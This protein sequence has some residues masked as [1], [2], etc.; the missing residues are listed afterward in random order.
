M[1][2]S[3]SNAGAANANA[4]LLE[5]AELVF[6]Q[7]VRQRLGVNPSY[8]NTLSVRREIGFWIDRA[9]KD[10]PRVVI[11]L[12]PAN[13]RR[14]F[15]FTLRSSMTV[16]YH[17]LG[18][19]TQAAI[20]AELELFVPVAVDVC[21]TAI[22]A[23]LRNIHRSYNVHPTRYPTPPSYANE[24]ELPLPFALAIQELGVFE[25]RS[26]TNRS[27]YIPTYPEDTLYEGRANAD[28]RISTYISF[29]R[30][31]RKLKIPLKSINPQ[32]K[33]GSPWWTYQVRNLHNTVYLVCTLP[34]SLYSDFSAQLRMLF[35]VPA[36]EDAGAAA[37]D[38]ITFPQ[39]PLFYGIRAKELRL[40][41]S[42]RTFLAL[43]HC[44]E[45]MWTF[46]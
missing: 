32:I 27:L 24:V 38:I 10:L 37:A 25:S 42:L 23:K 21:M 45:E 4:D 9:R 36:D 16:L 11:P 29:L 5:D 43:S 19:M 34:P 3:S 8:L 6:R 7:Q 35:V 1:A 20:D 41:I 2:P 30:T 14:G 31:L 22:Y 28:Y 26:V 13:M 44:P 12:S 46:S 15:A 40:G 33:I 39:E 18:S 17:N